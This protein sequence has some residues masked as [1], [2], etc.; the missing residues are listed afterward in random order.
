M[1]RRGTRYATV[2]RVL[3]GLAFAGALPLAAWWAVAGFEPG[4]A[5]LQTGATALWINAWLAAGLVLVL[6]TL[7]GRALLSAWSGYWA[8]WTLHALNAIKFSEMRRMLSPGDLVLLRQVVEH[9]DLFLEYLSTDWNGLAAALGVVAVAAL[10]AWR[11]PRTLPR[12]RWR[13]P[14]ALASVALAASLLSGHGFWRQHVTDA[15]LGGFEPWSPDLSMERSGLLAGLVRM[16]WQREERGALPTPDQQQMLDDFLSG[17]QEDLGRLAAP[18]M[19]MAL[20][21]LVVVQSEALFDP[22]ILRGIEPGEWLQGFR[23]LQA[24]GIHGE[25]TVP[26]YGGG[27]IRTE[28][29]VLTGYPMAAF[30]DVVFPYYGLTDHPVNALPAQLA[31][32]G[33]RT[34]AVHPYERS[35]WNRD[36]ALRN[37]G[38]PEAHFDGETVFRDP[39]RRGPFVTDEETFEGTLRL[40]AQDADA[41]PQFALVITVE[42]HSPWRHRK[43]IDAAERDAIPVPDVLDAEARKALQTYLLHLRHGDRALAT[44]AAA[45]LARTRPTLLL[46]YGDHLPALP[47]VYEQLGFDDGRPAWQ[48]QVPFLLVGNVPIVAGRRDLPSYGLPMLL[49]EQAGLPLHGYLARAQVIRQAA[50]DC[51][52]YR[53]CIPLLHF[54]ARM[55]L[56]R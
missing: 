29:E 33:Y 20:P 5:G 44:F 3:A 32:L 10:L 7:S 38:I 24:R 18:P 40:L 13:L 48:Q 2:L 36:A 1:V 22:A 25:L 39:R 46:V 50:L 56:A 51:A 35:F 43:N 49:L 19:P 17:K 6:W 37:L 52:D 34:F 26:T 28:F 15:R 12:L 30:P 21:D 27:T 9:V 14:L 23:T 47:R 41:A 54:A 42:N 16:G 55:D 8:L 11:E 45:L 53:N 4:L 31:A